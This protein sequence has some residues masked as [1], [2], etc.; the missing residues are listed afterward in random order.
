MKPKILVV[1]D[2]RDLVQLLSY[3]L[4]Q[5][6]YQV[7]PAYDGTSALELF[8]SKRPDLVIL[9]LMLPDKSGFQI[10]QEIRETAQG[11][12]RTPVIM[13]TAR[14]SEQERI[15]GFEAGTDDYVTKPF[16]PR[17]LVLR[18]KAMLERTT[19][20]KTTMMEVGS[21]KIYP[22]EFRVT[23]E[24]GEDLRLTP[25]EYRILVAL[26]RNPNVVKT[27]EQLLDEVWEE[28]S[29]EVLDRT[30]DA[31][32]KRLRS[33]LGSARDALETVRGIGY[34]L[35]IANSKP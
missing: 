12:H 34:R 23:A 27:R 16:S 5:A 22:E 20:A 4:Q 9:D 25:I 6:G 33:K 18:V 28:T 10:C 15:A 1:D 13:L 11:T 19:P 29:V 24:D 26:A 2:E 14:A 35:V 8:W 3:N 17:E 30:V 7:F 32:V 31:H 21:L